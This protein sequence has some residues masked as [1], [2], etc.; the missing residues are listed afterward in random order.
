LFAS[1][2]LDSIFFR[3]RKKKGNT[4]GTRNREEKIEGN[5][6]FFLEE[7]SGE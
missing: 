1:E 5:I 7:K 2:N 3:K 6:F 4:A